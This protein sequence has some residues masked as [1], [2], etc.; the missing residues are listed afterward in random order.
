MKTII[1]KAIH[2]DLKFLEKLETTCFPKFQQNN[3]R[4]IRNSITS[5]FQKVLIAEI[6]EGKNHK[7]AEPAAIPALTNKTP[8]NLL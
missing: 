7:P 1:R 5:E 3:M 2:D 4:S 6:K 8:H